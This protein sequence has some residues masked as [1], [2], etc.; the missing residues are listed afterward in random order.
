MQEASKRPYVGVMIET[1]ILIT[2]SLLKLDMEQLTHVLEAYISGVVAQG[3]VDYLIKV[4][5]SQVRQIG[6]SALPLW[7]CCCML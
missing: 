6:F 2:V 7:N 5:D 4:Q 1:A 3:Y